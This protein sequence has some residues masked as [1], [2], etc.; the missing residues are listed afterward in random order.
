M[1][2]RNENVKHKTKHLVV[3]LLLDST[4]AVHFY[5]LQNTRFFPGLISLFVLLIP[6]HIGGLS[7]NP[8]PRFHHSQ[9]QLQVMYVLTFVY[10][11]QV[12]VLF[13]PEKELPPL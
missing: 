5:Y 6:D 7:E 1:N 12:Q 10:Q 9:Y 4:V 13:F 8:S 2:N 3:R 11:S